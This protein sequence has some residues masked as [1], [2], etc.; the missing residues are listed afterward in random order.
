MA[1][2]QDPYEDETTLPEERGA[3][4]PFGG[5]RDEDFV[6]DDDGY[7]EQ[8][9]PYERDDGYDQQAAPYQDDVD[10]GYEQQAAPYQDEPTVDPYANPYL[11]AQD[12]SMTDPRIYGAEDPNAIPRETVY[13]GDDPNAVPAER[14][15]GDE[16]PNAASDLMDCCDLVLVESSSE[17]ANAEDFEDNDEDSQNGK[18]YLPAL[19]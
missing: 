12:S 16:D 2:Y 3:L 18:T 8:A 10:D 17:C 19:T 1:V 15:L 7:D 6:I 9:P 11:N 5:V 13:G 14:V 4:V